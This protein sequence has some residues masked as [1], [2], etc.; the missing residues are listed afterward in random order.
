MDKNKI[1]LA[2]K[3]NYDGDTFVGVHYGS[4]PELVSKLKDYE[5]N[6]VT[7]IIILPYVDGGKNGQN[8]EKMDD[9]E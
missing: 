2:I 3:V 4:V 1:K 5:L 9:K 7:Q 8:I 6:C